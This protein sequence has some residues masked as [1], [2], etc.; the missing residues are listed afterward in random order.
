MTINRH[1]S[2]PVRPKLGRAPSV[3]TA[4]LGIR[5]LTHKHL[6][7]GGGAVVAFLV[8]FF[9]LLSQGSE[10]AMTARMMAGVSP[11]AGTSDALASTPLSAQGQLVVVG[12]E[13][14]VTIVQDQPLSEADKQRLLAIISAH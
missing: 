13:L 5:G 14:P 1:T 6:F 2:S 4:P 10:G 3:T 11:A 8:L 7:L 9:L 12:E